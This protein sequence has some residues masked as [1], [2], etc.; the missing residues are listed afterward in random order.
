[1][2]S[3]YEIAGIHRN[4][5]GF[6]EILSDIPPE[7]GVPFEGPISSSL[8][9]N[10]STLITA[11][12]EQRLV[13]LAKSG[14]VDA[15]MELSRADHLK[16]LRTACRITRNWEDAEDA[17][18]S[19]QLRAFM[20]IRSFQGR[21]KFSSWMTRIVINA[22]PAMLRKK[23]RYS[24]SSVERDWNNNEGKKCLAIADERLCPL[25]SYESREQHERL[26]TALD[27]LRP[28]LRAVIDLRL[29]DG[30]SVQQIAKRLDIS[31]PAVKSRLV[32]RPYDDV[33]L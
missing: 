10:T 21:S 31:V 17:V 27:R 5:A 29:G 11:D 25:A 26:M 23:R 30:L 1:M 6:R 16:L 28:R 33:P 24:E 9:A 13:S 15:F 7:Y 2:L 19:A 20:Q 32:P 14:N 4:R 3:D 18:Q 22:A 12:E 8:S